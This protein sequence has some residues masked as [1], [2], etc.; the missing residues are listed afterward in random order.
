M[1]YYKNYDFFIFEYLN[2]PNCMVKFVVRN[3]LSWQNKN[4]DSFWSVFAILCIQKGIEDSLFVYGIYNA[5]ILV[6]NNLRYLLIFL[7]TDCIF[8]E[9]EFWLRTV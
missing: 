7:F 1:I 6:L 4:L 5:P 9:R 8:F 3:V 2:H